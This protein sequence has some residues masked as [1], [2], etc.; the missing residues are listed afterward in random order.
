[1]AFLGTLSLPVGASA[2]PGL[3]LGFTD[4]SAFAGATSPDNATNL[5]HARDAKASVARFFLSW[6]SVAPVEP[7]T[8]AAAADP[9]WTGYD[10]AK[11]DQA[12][13]QIAAASM[14]VLPVVYEAPAWAEGTG[15]PSKSA[16]ET[17]RPG[18]W[19]PAPAALRRFAVALA[20]RYSGTYADPLTPGGM[21]PAVRRWQAWNEPNLTVYLAP[22]WKKTGASYVPASPDLYRKLQNAFYAGVKSVSPES[23]VGTA[24]TAPYGD[25]NPGEPRMPPVT[26]WRS[27]LCVKGVTRLTSARCR[28]KVSFDAIAH[29]PYPIGPPDRHARN[30]GDVVIPDLGKITRLLAVAQKAGTVL[31]RRPKQ[32][33]ATEISWDSRPDPGGLPLATQARYLEGALYTLWRQGVDLVAWYLMRDGAPVPSYATT[34]QSGIFLR[35]TTPAQDTPKPSFT[36]FRF[37]FTAYRSKGV[38]RLWGMVPQTGVKATVIIEARQGSK[39]VQAVRLRSGTNRIFTGRLTVGRGTQLR[40]RVGDDISLPW[41]TS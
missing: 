40:A 9:S 11:T 24:G 21:L 7:P 30:P 10:W 27:L 25:L 26:F 5:G 17:L 6:R 14:D 2:A 31:P 15:R 19:K 16:G 22:Q 13:R 18:A 36:A 12:V 4:D 29:H 35:G 1:M 33:W 41:K 8:A 20:R 34:Y 28:T 37:P 3:S 39:W 32:L 38:A 23:V